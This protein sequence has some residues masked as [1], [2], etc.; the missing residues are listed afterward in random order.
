MT[1]VILLNEKIAAVPILSASGKRRAVA[2]IDAEDAEMCSKHKWFLSAGYPATKINGQNCRL[3]RIL[4]GEVRKGF[5]VDHANTIVLDARKKNLRVC[6]P[7]QNK[8]NSFRHRDNTS[9]FK[10]VTFC[11]ATGKW[12]AS[13][14]KNGANKDLGRHIDKGQAAAAY[15]KAA[16]ELFGE[17]ARMNS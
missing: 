1:T 9:G 8:A 4:M 15:N 14:M 17:F 6:T 16:V 10:G 12:R 3:H 5:Q 2:I 13:I 7:S 11:R